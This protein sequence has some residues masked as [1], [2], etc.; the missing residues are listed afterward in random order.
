MHATR[1]LLNRPYN[2]VR[3]A[4][5]ISAL[6]L[7]GFVAM[8]V[9]GEGPPNPFNQPVAVNLEL[10]AM[11][12]VLIGLA[13]GWWKDC[14]GAIM[15]FMGLIAFCAV[16]LSTNGNPPGPSFALFAIPGILYLIASWGSWREQ[17]SAESG[18][19]S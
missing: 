3:W 6:L 16:E 17:L 5:R 12:G 8:F 2:V 7:I 10:A 18:Y 14:L 1:C 11:A 9:I 19:T 4:A 15:T 13:I